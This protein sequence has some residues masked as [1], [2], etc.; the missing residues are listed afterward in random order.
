MFGRSF[1][2]RLAI[3]ARGGTDE[4]KTYDRVVA[5]IRSETLERN[6]LC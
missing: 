1:H 3:N 4:K 5:Q 2:Q 6:S